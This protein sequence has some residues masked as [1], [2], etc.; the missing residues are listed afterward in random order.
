MKKR[1]FIVGAKRSPIGAFLGT[2]K[3]VH[4]KEMGVQVLKKLLEETK[5]PKDEIKTPPQ[6]SLAVWRSNEHRRRDP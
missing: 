3:N 2:L 1:V 4:P 5:V 6:V